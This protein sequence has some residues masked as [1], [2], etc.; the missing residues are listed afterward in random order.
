MRKVRV[1]GSVAVSLVGLVLAADQDSYPRWVRGVMVGFLLL[2]SALGIPA[3]KPVT[4]RAFVAD[5]DDPVAAVLEQVN[6][7]ADG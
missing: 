4:R 7:P 5:H 2:A 1:F 3:A 6:G